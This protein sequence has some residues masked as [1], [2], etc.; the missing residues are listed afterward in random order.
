MDDSF[1]PAFD[2]FYAG[3]QQIYRNHMESSFPT[4]TPDPF[5]YTEGPK[6]IKII[7]GTAV[8]TFIDKKTGDIFKSASWR[9]PA[10]HARGNLFDPSN[11]LQFIGPYGP[12]YLR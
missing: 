12:A 5:S 4:L 7:V 8:T 9:A 2:I 6:F 3:Y 11:G 10:K 1:K